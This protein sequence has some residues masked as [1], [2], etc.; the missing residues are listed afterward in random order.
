MNLYF[1]GILRHQGLNIYAGY[2]QRAI[3]IYKFGDI[4]AY[5]RGVSGRQDEELVSVR[6]TY[7]LPLA[8]PDLSIGPVLY[9]KRIRANL[10]Y[11][12]AFTINSGN[13]EDVSAVGGDLLAEIHI[14]RFPA[15]LEIGVRYA[16][17]PDD[18]SPYWSFLLS[19]G[20]SSFYVNAA[21]GSRLIDP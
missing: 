18:A 10:F 12:H 9:I 1:P 16:Y 14:L 13:A 19:V 7:A 5:P 2:Q 15:P 20:F 4:L 17:L 3:G 8:Y 11:D 6:S 21:T